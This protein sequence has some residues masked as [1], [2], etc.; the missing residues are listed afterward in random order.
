M[1]KPLSRSR[2]IFLVIATTTGFT[3][4]SA[5]ASARHCGMAGGYG[6]PGHHGHAYGKPFY[7]PRAMGFA[8]GRPMA[9]P[10]PGA[11][12][13]RGAG[14][15]GYAKQKD[16]VETAEA[17]GKFSTL[18]TAVKAAGL[19]DALK[20]DGPLTVFAPTDEAFAK[21]AKAK[22]EELLNDKDALARVLT[23]HVVPARLSATE[24]NVLTSA[25]TLQGQ[26]VAIN[27]SDGVKVDAATVVKPDVRA[28]NGL[29]H[30]IDMVLLPDE[31]A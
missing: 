10:H 12:A 26:S 31:S 25:K 29:I 9:P 15:A 11:Y 30:V 2:F 27:T 22:L 1:R 13:K 3:L 7:L 8:Y 19:V 16:I 4:A 21:L 6:A 20:A 5:E 28:S 14:K 17:A 18:I 24:I 23:Y